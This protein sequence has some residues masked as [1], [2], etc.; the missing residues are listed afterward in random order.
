MGAVHSDSSRA[1]TPHRHLQQQGREPH[2]LGRGVRVERHRYPA[3]RHAGLRRS[4]RDRTAQVWTNEANSHESFASVFPVVYNVPRRPV[5][6]KLD[7]LN[8]QTN[9]DQNDFYRV[10]LVELPRRRWG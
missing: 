10:T 3:Y 6:I 9:T 8:A 1:L 5:T 7:R 4:Q 2:H